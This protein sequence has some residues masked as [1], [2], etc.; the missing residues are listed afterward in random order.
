MNSDIRKSY[1]KGNQA[2]TWSKLLL[3][4][5]FME[6]DNDLLSYEWISLDDDTENRIK[7]RQAVYSIYIERS[8]V[9]F[10]SD[11]N[12]LWLKQ[13]IGHLLNSIDEGEIDQLEFISK[14]ISLVESPPPFYLERYS[15]LKLADFTDD[16]TTI[17]PAD[18]LGNGDA[19]PN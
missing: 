8:S 7:I 12:L 4:P 6:V 1:F 5:L 17:N 13:T 14:V 16:V 3:H 9:L 11:L 2:K 15:N 19:Q 18:L 10:S